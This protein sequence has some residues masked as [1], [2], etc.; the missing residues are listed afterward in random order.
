MSSV[1]CPECDSVRIKTPSG[2]VCPKGHGK[3]QP[4][5]TRDELHQAR[6]AR[7]L[8]TM[9]NA[10]SISIHRYEINGKLYRPTF[11]SKTAKSSRYTIPPFCEPRAGTIAAINLRGDPQCFEQCLASSFYG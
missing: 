5:V 2:A 9:P 6:Y 11:Y 10:K 3:I 7:W 4:G 1:I 8:A